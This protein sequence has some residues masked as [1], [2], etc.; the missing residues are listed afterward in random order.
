MKWA[1]PALLFAIL[2][3][4]TPENWLPMSFRLIYLGSGRFCIAKL[5][6]ASN[7]SA[8][9]S[10]GV[11]WDVAVL[12]GVEICRGSQGPEVLKHKSLLYQSMDY[13]IKWVL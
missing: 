11:E 2:Q 10:S 9:E 1:G 5:F 12:M 6:R 8:S 7:N 3:F 4:V 13:G